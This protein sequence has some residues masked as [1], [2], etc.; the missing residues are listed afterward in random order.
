MIFDT[1]KTSKSQLVSSEDCKKAY[2]YAT[3]SSK[4][5]A[6][7]VDG[8]GPATQ[9]RDAKRKCFFPLP[10]SSEGSSDNAK[11][12]LCVQNKDFA[13]GMQKR[14][15]ICFCI[16]RGPEE[17]R[18]GIKIRW[19]FWVDPMDLMDTGP[20]TTQNANAFWVHKRFIGSADNT[21]RKCFLHPL[22][23]YRVR[24]QRHK[25]QK[26]FASLEDPVNLGLCHAKSLTKTE[27]N[28]S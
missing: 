20:P 8:P 3:I 26:L 19:T 4:F 27:G 2:S 18:V 11:Q 7:P 14:K 15:I 1:Q 9:L 16:V 17:D 12:R 21:K 5:W 25:K 24:R 22:R 28:C 6:P 10:G 13:L 23:I